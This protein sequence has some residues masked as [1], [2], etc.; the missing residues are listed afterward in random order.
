[1]Q[2]ALVATSEHWL[3]ACGCLSGMTVKGT[4]GNVCSR[5]RLCQQLPARNGLQLL[6]HPL[7]L[8]PAC[9]VTSKSAIESSKCLERFNAPPAP[10]KGGS[11]LPNKMQYYFPFRA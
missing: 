8:L 11:T 9:D 3:T 6:K 10:H 7:Q 4:A 5:M 2:L 1:M